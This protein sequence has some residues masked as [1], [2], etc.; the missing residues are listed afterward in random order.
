MQM[1]AQ[2]KGKNAFEIYEKRNVLD[3]VLRTS[4]KA[5]SFFSYTLH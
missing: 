3:K 5:P 2:D 4:C 1:S